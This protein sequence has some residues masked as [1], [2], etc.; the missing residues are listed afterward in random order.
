[1][2]DI[3]GSSL[4]VGVQEVMLEIFRGSFGCAWTHGWLVLGENVKTTYA[5][6]DAIQLY[7]Y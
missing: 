3:I 1:M 7:I 2:Q 4:Q 6:T 5:F